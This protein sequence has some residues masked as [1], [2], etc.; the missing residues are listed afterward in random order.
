DLAGMFS[1]VAIIAF[2]ICSTVIDLYFEGV[3][4]ENAGSTFSSS[5]GV[6]C[7]PMIIA[8]RKMLT[9]AGPLSF[10]ASSASPFTRAYRA[11]PAAPDPVAAAIGSAP[12]ADM[13]AK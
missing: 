9:V 12:A 5:Q 6:C 10:T 1:D 13:N 11:I 7:D 4:N 3:T 2:A 8:G